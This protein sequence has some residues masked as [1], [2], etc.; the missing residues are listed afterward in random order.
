VN[1]LSKR[2]LCGP[3]FFVC[4]S[5][6]EAAS[7]APRSGGFLPV[8]KHSPGGR[9]PTLVCFGSL[10]RLTVPAVLSVPL[11]SRANATRRV[12]NASPASPASATKRLQRALSRRLATL[13]W[14]LPAL[15]AWI[16]AW[17]IWAVAVAAQLPST[18]AFV[19]ASAASLWMAWPCKGSM[20]R[21][22]VLM[23]FPVSAWALGAASALPAWAWL[24]MLLPLLAAY[25]LRAW[26]DAPFFPTPSQALQGLDKLVGT[27]LRVLDAGCGLGH[28]LDALRTLWP[29]AKLHG[30]EYSAPLAW[31]AALRCA[32]CK[33]KATV[34]RGDLWATPWSD[35]DVVYV[36]QRPESMARVFAKA[37]KE[38]RPGAWLVSLEFEVPGQRPVARLQGPG[39]KPLWVYQPAG[40]L[41]RAAKHSTQAV[42]CR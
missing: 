33:T 20:R 5:S 18:V 14:P 36:F 38:Q 34:Q 7:S 19:L 13:H 9:R 32:V 1:V 31:G 8:F 11:R 35:F 10:G 25:P 29:Q 26:Q 15:L 4:R 42:R 22:L 12:G 3:F 30:V 27:P 40:A 21:G 39:R 2:A 17:C 23:G 24:L 37:A 28:G 41:A 6:T 16:G